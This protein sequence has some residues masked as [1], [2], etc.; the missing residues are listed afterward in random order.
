ML[1]YESASFSLFSNMAA[2]ISGF[3]IFF[4]VAVRFDWI[5]ID[6]WL[7][8]GVLKLFESTQIVIRFGSCEVRRLTR[9]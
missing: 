6:V 7:K 2:F 9:A 8:L 3:S 5:K 4:G 1:I